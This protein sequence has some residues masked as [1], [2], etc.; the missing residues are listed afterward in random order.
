MHFLTMRTETL[1]SDGDGVGDNADV[2]PEFGKARRLTR[3]V[4][5]SAIIQ[6]YFQMTRLR[7]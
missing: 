3:M 6:M 2:F 4:M 7:V 1:D 5:V